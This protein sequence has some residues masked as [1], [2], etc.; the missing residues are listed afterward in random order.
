MMR[1]IGRLFSRVK[2]QPDEER[3]HLSGSMFDRQYRELRAKYDAA[4]TTTDN[5]NHWANADSL[6]ANAAAT[7]GIRQRLRNRARYECHQSNSW[8]KGIVQSL[9]ND[10]IGTGPRLRLAIEPRTMD[11][12]GNVSPNALAGQIRRLRM[13]EKLFAEWADEVGLAA[14]LR[15]MRM[16]KA[17]DGEAFLVITQ[18]PRLKSRA[19]IGLSLVEADRVTT[20]G[21]TTPTETEHDGIAFDEFGNVVS[22]EIL[23]QHPGSGT[24][25]ISGSL[26]DSVTVPA[27]SVVHWYRADR[28]EQTRGVS[29]FVT[30]LPLF[31]QLR[32]YR[33]AV[34]DAAETA[35]DI[36]GVVRTSVAAVDPDELVA[37]DSVDIEQRQLLTL[38]QGWD[39]S[40]LKAEQ[41]TTTYAEF[42]DHNLNE[43]GRPVGMP[44]N[45]SK[46]NS[47]N[48]NYAS[49]RL[50]HQGYH[51][52][53]RVERADCELTVLSRVYQ[54]FVNSVK[55]DDFEQRRAPTFPA[56]SA[57]W[58]V[59]WYWDGFAH[60]DPNKEANAQQTRL[61]N[62]T[63]TLQIEY[64]LEGRDWEPAIQQRGR[65]IALLRELKLPVPSDARQPIDDVE[66]EDGIEPQ[67]RNNAQEAEA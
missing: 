14:K 65:E 37:G 50:D 17:V 26:V 62:H 19:K 2:S 8:A 67:T 34:M 15:T 12:L 56:G 25:Q 60:V 44:L 21:F 53:I 63:T 5:T 48:H 38:P 57:D 32:R 9:A 54:A 45:V 10:T 22:Y 35:A 46:G 49:G 31:A 20:P 47:Q 6:S 27:A 58:L 39:I 23:K 7:P 55:L 64:A 24:V 52:I 3:R 18:N 29:E 66:P 40:Q 42:S 16:S 28:P 41:P 51:K 11:R 30:S 4:R 61:N 1:L 59:D 43:L 13:I 36:A 33:E